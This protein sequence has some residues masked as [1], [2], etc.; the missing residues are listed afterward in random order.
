MSTDIT[1]MIQTKM[2]SKLEV[3]CSGQMEVFPCTEKVNGLQSWNNKYVGENH[4]NN[5]FMKGLIQEVF[6]R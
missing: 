5:H 6:E 2:W 1:E 4:Q 3:V